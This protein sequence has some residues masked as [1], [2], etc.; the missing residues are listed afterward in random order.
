MVNGYPAA[1]GKS[2]IPE[3]IVVGAVDNEG[4]QS[5]GTN[6]DPNENIPWVWAPGVDVTCA[7]AQS[8]MGGD[9]ETTGTSAGKFYLGR[10]NMLSS[11]VFNDDIYLATAT[12]AGLVAYFYSLD[13]PFHELDL[14]KSY[15]RF[16]A[17]PRGSD[18]GVLGVWNGWWDP[19]SVSKETKKFFDDLNDFKKSGGGK[20]PGE[21]KTLGD[22]FR[23][24]GDIKKPGDDKKPGH[25]KKPSEEKKPN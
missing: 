1:Y 18:A 9:Q 20:K 23:E 15:I 7:T 25:G 22:V 4:R 12:V 8:G 13:I 16:Q 24:L 5:I 3:M 19:S 11:S 17:Y 14:V 10:C 6:T 21:E 2:D